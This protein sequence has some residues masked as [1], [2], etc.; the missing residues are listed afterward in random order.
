M[1]FIPFSLAQSI[2][3]FRKSMCFK[4][5]KCAKINC[6]GIENGHRAPGCSCWPHGYYVE[7]AQ[8]PL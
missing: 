8:G 6:H 1:G 4:C 2:R 3:D 5:P 7:L